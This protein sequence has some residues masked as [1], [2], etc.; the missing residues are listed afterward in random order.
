MWSWLFERTPEEGTIEE[1]RQY[2]MISIDYRYILETID[3]HARATFQR[4]DV[5]DS[6][7]LLDRFD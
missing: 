6:D 5:L 3:S 7:D 2:E 4:R 1:T